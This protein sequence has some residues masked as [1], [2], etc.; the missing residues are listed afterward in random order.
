M[1]WE[2]ALSSVS[3]SLLPSKAIYLV[4][5][6]LF[7]F[8][9]STNPKLSN[10]SWKIKK[11]TKKENPTPSPKTCTY[12]IAIF[13]QVQK[14]RDAGSQD[15]QAQIHALHSPAPHRNVAMETNFWSLI[16]L[17]SSERKF[18]SGP[19]LP[20]PTFPTWKWCFPQDILV[21]ANWRL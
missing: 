3:Y 4:I 11:Q 17:T 10:A 7:L 5:H 20:H 19:N 18:H 12:T 8:H 15:T 16:S 21:C 6:E 13:I 1:M 14:N 2:S 9:I